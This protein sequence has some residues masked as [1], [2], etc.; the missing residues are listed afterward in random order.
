[1][2]DDSTG[3]GG[4]W[5]NMFPVEE[6][7]WK[8]EL[9][10]VRSS[11]V[12]TKCASCETFRPGHVAD[13][14]PLAEMADANAP[15]EPDGVAAP[16]HLA[17]LAE[18]EDHVG[19]NMNEDEVPL[20]EMADA[21]APQEPGVAAPPVRLAD[22]APR[23]DVVGPLWTQTNNGPAFSDSA[24][25]GMILSVRE[26]IRRGEP[27]QAPI[28][29]VLTNGPEGLLGMTFP[30]LIHQLGPRL[31][32]TGPDLDCIMLVADSVED[33]MVATTLLPACGF[34]NEY[35]LRISTHDN[36]EFC[37]L[38]LSRTPEDAFHTIYNL[39]LV[40]ARLQIKISLQGYVS[41][42]TCA[43][44]LTHAQLGEICVT[45]GPGFKIELEKFH[46]TPAQQRTLAES[47]SFL[48]LDRCVLAENGLP[49]AQGPLSI[50]GLHLKQAQPFTSIEARDTL[51]SQV[52]TSS[53][54]QAFLV[55]YTPIDDAMVEAIAST[56]SEVQLVSME[57]T[58]PQCNLVLRTVFARVMATRFERLI[59]NGNLIAALRLYQE[60][61]FWEEPESHHYRLVGG[62]DQDVNPWQS[63]DNVAH[64]FF[65][66]LQR[67]VVVLVAG[68]LAA[69][70][71]QAE[72]DVPIAQ[73]APQ[74]PVAVPI[75]ADE[76][77]VEEELPRRSKR[78]R[79]EPVAQEPVAQEQEEE[80][81]LRRSKR[82]R[83]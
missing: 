54:C 13:E 63:A 34:L 30:Q 2:T 39:M 24:R 58:T 48:I 68:A 19:P 35:A 22:L 53:S 33:D 3:G 5:G 21:N 49:F 59:A 75:L 50:T 78:L 16:V 12:V 43:L 76:E 73:L 32:V 31:L 66:R 67:G 52:A 62:D 69:L 82:R 4:G 18:V 80:Q 7:S 77:E 29:R 25:Q 64:N 70:G 26:D 51:L 6:G 42:G 14:I 55:T 79:E 47:S 83:L 27:I 45:G 56:A 44:G 72:D 17:D 9:C 11:G 41:E 46:L 8:C 61:M 36:D 20:V 65:E 74:E 71:N 81:P 28:Q 1:M 57:G 38:V 15:Q 37:I 23:Q 60:L 10:G 40:G